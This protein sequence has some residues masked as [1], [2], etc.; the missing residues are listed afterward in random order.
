MFLRSKEFYFL[1]LTKPTIQGA[2]LEKTIKHMTKTMRKIFD[3]LRKQNIKPNGIRKLECTYRPKGYFHPHFHLVVESKEHAEIIRKEWLKEYPNAKR[4]SN[5]IRP[6]TDNYVIELMKYFTKLLPN[7]KSKEKHINYKAL[8]TIFQA[9]QNKRVYQPFGNIKKIKD[10]EIS[11]TEYDISVPA[12]LT[13]HVW[14]Q[15]IFDW[16][17]VQTAEILSYYQPTNHDKELIK[18]LKNENNISLNKIKLI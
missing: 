1:T 16:I 13:K 17:D 15:S 3:R 11:N 10:K 14:H 8:D 7:K 5:D 12:K 2:E 4:I 9:M 18:L 6:C